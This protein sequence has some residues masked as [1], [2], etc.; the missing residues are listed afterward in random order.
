MNKRYRI[1]AWIPAVTEP[2]QPM[3]HDEATAE[4]EHLRN[5]QPENRY[6]LEEVVTESDK[7][8]LWFLLREGD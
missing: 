4:L 7:F 6:E 8:G 5:L 3:E 2:E 1:R